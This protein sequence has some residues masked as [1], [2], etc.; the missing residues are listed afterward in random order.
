[1]KSALMA[2]VVLGMQFTASDVEA[3]AERE[4]TGRDEN[5]RLSVVASCGSE[6]EMACEIFMEYFRRSP[7]YELVGDDSGILG[8]IYHAHL[9]MAW[10]EDSAAQ[11][12]VTWSIGNREVTGP[13]VS[14][15]SGLPDPVLYLRLI[16]LALKVAEFPGSD[17]PFL[18]N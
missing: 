17:L 12:A 5:G 1:M 18:K 15:G 3:S 4:M 16:D 13:N 10:M 8:R 2:L 14:L 6:I 7:H 9:D 11:S